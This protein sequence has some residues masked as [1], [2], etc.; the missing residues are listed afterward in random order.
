MALTRLDPA[1]ATGVGIVSF[2]VLKTTAPAVSSSLCRLFNAY[3]RTSQFL[4]RWKAATVI[5]IPKTSYANTPDE[6]LPISI[7]PVIARVMESFVHTRVYKYLKHHGVL[8]EVQSGFRPKHCTQDVLLKTVD[9]WR[10]NLEKN[11]ITVSAFIDLSKAFDSVCHTTLL[12]KLSLYGFCGNS[13]Q[14]F[15][16]YLH[17]RRQSG[18]WWGRVR[19]D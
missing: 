19:Q 12:E 14:R 17:S 10:C 11:E 2:R 1:K 7:L 3:L 9:D 6:Y 15:T 16:S 5:P 13:L 8:H 18:V 4:S